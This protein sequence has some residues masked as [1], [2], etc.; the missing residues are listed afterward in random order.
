MNGH[1]TLQLNGI[2]FD[3][4][5]AENDQADQVAR[6]TETTIRAHLDRGAAPQ[7]I[8]V[9]PEGSNTP[10]LLHINGAAIATAIVHVR[11]EPDPSFGFAL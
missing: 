5:V 7:P 6:N 9:V 10:V 4:R 1:V 3:I 2:E 11:A 8:Y